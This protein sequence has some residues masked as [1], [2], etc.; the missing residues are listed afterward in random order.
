MTEIKSDGWGSRIGLVFA[1]A[2]N[3]VGL[4]NF[5]RFPVQAVQNGGGAFIIPYLVCFLLL[6]VP[7]MWMEWALGRAGGAHGKHSPPFILDSLRLGRIWKYVGVFGIFTNLAVAA[8]YIY[9]ESW[10]LTYVW[11]SLTHFFEGMG[12]AQVAQHFTDYVSLAGSSGYTP[13][14]IYLACV[15]LHVLILSTSLEKGVE[16]VSKVAMPILFIGGLAL[17][18]LALSIQPGQYNASFSGLEGLRLVWTPQYESLLA[19][20]TWLAAAGQVFFTLSVGMGTIK[21]FAS[22]VKRDEDIALNAMAAGWAN[23]FVEVVIGGAL[24]IPVAVGFLGPETVIKAVS[25]GGLGLGFKSLPYLFLNFGEILGM[26]VGA[27]F[28]TLLFLAGITSS[29]AM[30]VPWQAFLADEFNWSKKKSAWAFS[31]IVLI[32]G[33]PTVFYFNEG[34]FDDFDYLAGTVALVIFGMAESL[35]FA[36]GWGLE[37]GWAEIVRGADIKVP[38][39]FRPVIKYVTPWMLVAIFLSALLAPV[40]GNWAGAVSQFFSGDGWPLAPNSLISQVLLLPQ[41]AA[42][43]TSAEASRQ[44]YVLVAGRLLLLVAFVALCLMVKRAARRQKPALNHA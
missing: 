22:Y 4:G 40:G 10:T 41:R 43:E 12:P 38:L 18:I 2:G 28:F 21:C 35:L 14:I 29:L 31:A 26:L 23:E 37:K 8:Y 7:L 34:V 13:V 20:G 33:L 15:L 17:A 24:L 9:L 25:S 5:L 16:L 44:L 3:A 1:M 11:Y 36:Y 32:L 39:F 42:A 27:L 30:G 19:P 6:G